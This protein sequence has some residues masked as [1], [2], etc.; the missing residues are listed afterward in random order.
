MNKV[1]IIGNGFDLDL[2]LKTSYSDFIKCESFKSLTD[3]NSLA[4]DIK[5]EYE[6]KKWIDLE[7]FLKNYIIAQSTVDSFAN[8]YDS[9]L[10]EEF[11]A[12]QDLLNTYINNKIAYC[13]INK[14][15]IARQLL[16][17]IAE[18]GDYDIYNFNYTNFKDICNNCEIRKLECKH[19]HGQAINNSIILGVE[20]H[21]DIPDDHVYIIKSF[22]HHY[23]SRNIRQALKNASDIIIFGHSLGETDYHY[24]SDFFEEQSSKSL[25]EKEKNITI[26]TY[27]RESELSILK[28]LR[29]MNPN[30]DIGRLRDMNNFRIFCTSSKEDYNNIKSF[31]HKL[32]NRGSAKLISELEQ[33]LL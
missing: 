16:N 26:F 31:L 10:K 13:S 25:Y 22:S 17:A 19:V 9:L 11:Y 5:K 28:Q 12:L 18:N 29:K 27:D 2:G 14:D 20:A 23:I 1:L 4:K 32:S 8:K 33:R 6:I 15:S 30:N 3:N 21:K 7:T 24:F